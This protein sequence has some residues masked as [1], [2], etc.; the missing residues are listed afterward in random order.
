VLTK[1]LKSAN[2][3]I[4]AYKI[5]FCWHLEAGAILAA[6]CRSTA[7]SKS[8]GSRRHPGGFLQ[9]YGLVKVGWQRRHPGGFLQKYGLVKAGWKPALP[10]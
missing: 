5:S 4:L 1:T 10:G 2:I 9:K 6:F 7:L 8:A 3:A